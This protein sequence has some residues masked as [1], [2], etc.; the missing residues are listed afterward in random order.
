MIKG[1]LPAPAFHRKKKEE[2]R[3][4]FNKKS[5]HQS[6]RIVFVIQIKRKKQP[7]SIFWPKPFFIYHQKDM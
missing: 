6:K 1:E 4:K 7:V 5:T 3:G 2:A